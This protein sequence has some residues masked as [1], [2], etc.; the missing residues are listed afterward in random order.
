MGTV[1]LCNY[2]WI[3]VGVVALIHIEPVDSMFF[4]DG[5]GDR[6]ILQ[7][8]RVCLLGRVLIRRFLFCFF[9]CTWTTIDGFH[10]QVV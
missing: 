3:K 4:V 7:N 5:L 10:T 8:D 6:L 1:F 2:W 9:E